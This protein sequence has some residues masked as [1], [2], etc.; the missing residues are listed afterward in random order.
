MSGRA[1]VRRHDSPALCWRE[2][3]Q[4]HWQAAHA[5]E[6]QPVGVSKP[7][8]FKVHVLL[9]GIVLSPRG[10]HRNA[11]ENPTILPALSASRLARSRHGQAHNER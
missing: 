1:S 6:G 2:K 5:M 7:Q 9:A 4:R 8:G 10:T 11:T 3:L